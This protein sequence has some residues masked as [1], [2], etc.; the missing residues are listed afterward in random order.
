M[1]FLSPELVLYLY[2]STIKQHAEYCCHVLAGVSKCYLNLL[3]KLQKYC[4][5][6][7]I[8]FSQSLAHCQNAAILS[9]FLVVNLVDVLLGFL[10]WFWTVPHYTKEIDANSFF[11]W[12][13]KLC[14]YLPGVSFLLTFNQNRFKV[15]VNKLFA[16]FCLRYSFFSLWI[17]LLY[18]YIYIQIY[19]YR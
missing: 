19:R 15:N 16:S 9:L 3:D 6:W 5:S 11:P 4:Q 17:F 14:N 10:N 7:A 12:V 13:A 2:K 8:S 18:I 1:K